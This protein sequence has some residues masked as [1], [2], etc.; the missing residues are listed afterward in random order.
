MDW[1]LN[2]DNIRLFL[3][4]ARA[5]SLRG[6]AEQLKVN[7]ATVSRGIK[8]LEKSLSTRLFDRSRSGLTL[9]QPGEVLM[10]SAEKMEQETRTI[11]AQIA[12]SETY[13]SGKVRVSVPS[14]LAYNFLPPLFARFSQKFPEIDL[15]IQV[16]SRFSDIMCFEADVS[17]RIAWAVEEDVVVRKLVQYAKCIYANPEYLDAR[18]NFEI[19]DGQGLEWIGWGDKETKPDWVRNSPFPNAVVRHSMNDPILQLEAVASG[20]GI[21]YLPSFIGDADPRLQRVPGVEPTADRFLWIL[22]HKDLRETARI[23]AFVD[24]M[25]KA[26]LN[27]YAQILGKTTAE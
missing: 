23:R 14:F 22:L 17:I 9:T 16:T 2:W 26:I 11:V 15:D 10:V 24:F 21:T 20:M 12:G 25:S 19:G 5:G 13:P 27:R 1:E 3:A 6:A 7:H 8:L 4:V 18:Q